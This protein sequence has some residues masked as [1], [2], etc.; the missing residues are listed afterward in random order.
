[1]FG[2][3][4]SKETRGAAQVMVVSSGPI[5]G[6]GLAVGADPLA[7]GWSATGGCNGALGFFTCPRA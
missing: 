5:V 4:I 6:P 2:G 1:V 7:A 3:R